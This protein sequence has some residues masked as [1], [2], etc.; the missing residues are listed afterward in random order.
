MAE[1]L[2]VKGA[3][4]IAVVCEGEGRHV[5]ALCLCHQSVQCGTAVQKRIVRVYVQMH[6][7]A[8]WCTFR[9][10]RKNMIVSQVAALLVCEVR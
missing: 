2:K 9:R 5:E 8:F 6:K 10:I 1:M 4:H 3:E 7:I